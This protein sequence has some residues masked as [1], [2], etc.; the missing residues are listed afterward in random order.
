MTVCPHPVMDATPQRGPAEEAGQ[1]SC[2]SPDCFEA[3][4]HRQ[5]PWTCGAGLEFDA[6]PT[7]RHDDPPAPQLPPANGQ[8]PV[9]QHPQLHTDLDAK[10]PEHLRQHCPR[11][12]PTQREVRVKDAPSPRRFDLADEVQAP[13]AAGALEKACR[14]PAGSTLCQSL[15]SP[16]ADQ[17]RQGLQCGL[18]ELDLDPATE[19]RRPP[20][21]AANLWMHGGQPGPEH[22]RK[23][24][25]APSSPHRPTQCGRAQPS[26]EKGEQSET[27]R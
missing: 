22:A 27:T 24:I 21:E 10:L 14:H 4:D 1:G 9:R 18:R 17:P 23:Q 8:T 6:Q 26:P 7:H 12:L 19:I 25:P 11:I 13:I 20:I 16:S 5:P 15:S 3:T 2:E